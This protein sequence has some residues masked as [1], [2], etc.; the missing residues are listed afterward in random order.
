[1]T[2][3]LIFWKYIEFALTVAEISHPKANKAI[4]AIQRLK[5][6]EGE[7]KDPGMG[8]TGYLNNNDPYQALNDYVAHI[9]DNGK[10]PFW[11]V[12]AE[13]GY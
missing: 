3:Y 10:P 7:G 5:A 11:L 2:P 13:R 1:M 6:I 8:Q 9:Y 12:A 4:V